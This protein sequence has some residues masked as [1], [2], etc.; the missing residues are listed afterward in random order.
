MGNRQLAETIQ[1]VVSEVDRLADLY[2]R[3]WK[4]AVEEMEIS[5]GMPSEHV[6]FPER[7][8]RYYRCGKVANQKLYEI[9]A[10]QVQKD[11]DLAGRISAQSVFSAL[12]IEIV[13][14]CIE[15]HQTVTSK[16]A[17]DLFEKAKS[18]A[19]ANAVDRTYF[20][21]VFAIR[22]GDGDEFSIG[23][24]TFTR[25]KVFFEVHKDEWQQSIQSGIATAGDDFGAEQVRKNI[26]WLY[27]SSEKYYR[28][29]PCIASVQIHGAEPD[30]GRIAAK[31]VL[32]SSFNVLRIFVPSSRRQFIGLAEDSPFSIG[33]S[34]IEQESNG[35]FVAWHSGKQGEP[36]GPNDSISRLRERMPQVGFIEQLIMKQRDWM[37]LRPIE[38][39]LMN[40]LTWYGE[41]W[42]ERM[43]VAKLVKFAVAL[44]TLM[45]TGAKEAITETL[46]ERIALLCG[47]D[48]KEREQLYAEAREVY[49]TR[50]KAVHG[51][52][53]EN[54][55]D[56]DRT[57]VTAEK[58]CVFALFSC[59]S[60]FPAFLDSGRDAKALAEFFKV[61]KLGGLEEAAARIGA[62][63]YP[64]PVAD[65]PAG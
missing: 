46:A 45:M 56:I 62:Q 39:R 64:T 7:A 23:A 48:T 51:A 21:P 27:D 49:R 37:P 52:I 65:Q 47:S 36:H 3:D 33:R 40:G 34:W 59:A 58:L 41:A 44:E 60:L 29:F 10:A 32:E 9:A 16:L 1:F 42:K 5:M 30:L 53:D 28:E 6:Q 54:T 26:E 55:T 18:K 57:N 25:T 20:F 8:R 19:L 38:K 15:E 13:Q 11:R 35:Q 24:A 61:A 43:P 4:S 12:Q 17:R 50:S 63:M 31:A 14:E 22:T 2:Q